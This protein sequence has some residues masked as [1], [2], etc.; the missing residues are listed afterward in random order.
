ML[1]E[2][3]LQNN[4]KES[5]LAEIVKIIDTRQLPFKKDGWNF[6]WRLAAKE[7][8]SQLFALILSET[9]E[10]EGLIKLKTEYDMMIM[11]I[12]EIAPHNIGKNKRYYDVAGSLIAFGC[13]ESFNLDNNYKGFLSFV[14]KTNL[15]NF[16]SSKYGAIQAL[17]QKICIPPEIGSKLINKYLNNN[18]K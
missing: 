11:D 14:S 1:M 12:V 3:H 17:G 16:Y 4:L 13:W 15:V 9:K 18:I 5:V 8:N 10:I 2:I 6:N 7:A